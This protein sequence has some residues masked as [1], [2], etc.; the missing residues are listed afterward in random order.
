MKQRVCYRVE[1]QFF[2]DSSMLFAVD[3]ELYYINMRCVY[4]LAQFFC[5]R[6]E[7]HCNRQTVLSFSLT[8]E[9]AGY[10]TFFSQQL[11]SFL[12]EAISFLTFNFNF[13]HNCVT[14]KLSVTKISC[15]IHHHTKYHS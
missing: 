10:K 8:I 15:L 11:C 4:D 7:C 3:D 12:T 9:V 5:R 1:L 2:H 14:L 13:L 6:R